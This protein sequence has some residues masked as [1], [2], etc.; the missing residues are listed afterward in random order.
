MRRRH[1]FD[2]DSPLYRYRIGDWVKYKHHDRLKFEYRWKGPYSVV[3]VG[4]PGTYWLMSP[5]GRRFDSTVPESDLRTWLGSPGDTFYDGTQ[6]SRPT[7]E[8][9]LLPQPAQQQEERTPTA[10][11]Q[12]ETANP[13]SLGVLATSLALSPIK[14]GLAHE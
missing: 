7:G 10:D 1:N 12:L 14:G 5:D 3:D 9:V 6:R 11:S 2:P 4:F 13:D 8:E